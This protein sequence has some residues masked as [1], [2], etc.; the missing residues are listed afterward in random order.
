MGPILLWG[1]REPHVRSLCGQPCVQTPPVEHSVLRFR[2]FKFAAAPPLWT[3]YP[4][5][6][7]WQWQVVLPYCVRQPAV[8]C[9]TE[10]FCKGPAAAT[11]QRGLPDHLGFAVVVRGG[12]TGAI[13]AGAVA[14]KAPRGGGVMTGRW[15]LAAGRLLTADC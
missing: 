11:E 8:S 2:L 14:C 7:A 15:P 1:S 12:P 3:T 13:S 4:P 6:A 10:G 9:S 5:C